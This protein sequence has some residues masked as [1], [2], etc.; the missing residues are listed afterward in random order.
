MPVHNTGHATLY[1]V[2]VIMEKSMS[3]GGSDMLPWQPWQFKYPVNKDNAT[4]E[5][6]LRAHVICNT[7]CSVRF[8][9]LYY[10]LTRVPLRPR[11]KGRL[12]TLSSAALF[13]LVPPTCWIWHTGSTFRLD[14][15]PRSNIGP[16]TWIKSTGAWLESP[17]LKA[18]EVVRSRKWKR[19]YITVF[20]LWLYKHKPSF[21]LYPECCLPKHN[22]FQKRNW[23]PESDQIRA[24]ATAA[25]YKQPE[26]RWQIME[27]FL[28]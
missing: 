14:S 18:A 12:R 6:G 20:Q 22:H 28:L 21:P 1:P 9:P 16:N 7:C 23:C 11:Q 5:A 4:G 17:W 27:T 10:R 25:Q 26:Q 15:R 19:I 13:L 24:N 8:L 3:P 2:K